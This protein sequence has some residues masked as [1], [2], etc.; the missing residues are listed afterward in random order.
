MNT[1]SKN[2]VVVSLIAGSLLFSAGPALA[3]DAWRDFHRHHR[4]SHWH[5]AWDRADIRR[6]TFRDRAHLH[7]DENVRQDR[8]EL[9]R[10]LYRGANPARINSEHAALRRNYWDLRQ[11]QSGLRID[12]FGRRF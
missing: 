1:R 3:R 10:D 8:R 9:R 11:H 4:G 7:R 5:H 6:D 12:R 2:V